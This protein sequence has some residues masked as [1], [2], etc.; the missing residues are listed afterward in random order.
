[1]NKYLLST[2]SLAILAASSS[3]SATVLTVNSGIGLDSNAFRLNQEFETEQ[4][5]YLNNSIRLRSD[6]KSPF[7][8]NL[9]YANK[10]YLD[11]DRADTTTTGF[12]FGYKGKWQ[13]LKYQI[14]LGHRDFEK[15]YVSRFSGDVYTSKGEDFPDRYNFARLTPKMSLEYKLNKQHSLLLSGEYRET[16]YHDYSEFGLSN[17]DYSQWIGAAGWKY[18]PTKSFTSILNFDLQQRE[19]DG[20]LAKDKDGKNIE[21]LT[22]VYD[23]WGVDWTGRH[24]FSKQTQLSLSASYTDKSDNASG[25]YD[26][27]YLTLG[28]RLRHK[29]DS[30]TQISASFMYTDLKYLR[31]SIRDNSESDIE[32]NDE[33]PDNNGFVSR[34]SIDKPFWSNGKN[35]AKFYLSGTYY[36]YDSGI[37]QYTY[38]RY[39]VETGIKL[40]FDF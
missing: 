35:Q 40:R 21:G 16:D 22:S 7:V 26:T 11:D 5:A 19:Y 33:L 17:L 24:R 29:T 31:G 32:T 14:S 25:Y 9:S 8:F 20:R 39:K 34:L 4:Q 10:T 15:T 28:A 6:F 12:T 37:K 13:A 23:Y 1:M 38:D 18:K 27:E 2:F 30:D 3:A 36:Q